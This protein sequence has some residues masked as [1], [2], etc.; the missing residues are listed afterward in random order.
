VSDISIFYS[1][2][3]N[4]HGGHITLSRDMHNPKT[5]DKLNIEAQECEDRDFAVGF[6]DSDGNNDGNGR[7]A[8]G[9]V[10]VLLAMQNFHRDG[11]IEGRGLPDPF[12]AP[13]VRNVW[14]VIKDTNFGDVC[15]LPESAFL[16]EIP[17][18]SNVGKDAQVALRRAIE[19]AGYLDPHN[20][21][22]EHLAQAL[23]THIRILFYG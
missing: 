19:L 13:P 10:S 14:D 16:K 21:V 1:G 15:E 12:D 9:L 8:G 6:F 4:A 7:I 20:A 23:I 11:F 3:T 2:H 17:A 18:D 22:T 5:G